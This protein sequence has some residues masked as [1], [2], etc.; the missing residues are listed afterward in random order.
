MQELYGRYNLVAFPCGNGGQ[1]MGL[2][3][4]KKATKMSDFKGMRVRTPGWFM[5]IMNYWAPRVT[6]LPGGEVY[7]ALRARRY[8]C[9]RIQL[10]G[11]QLSD[12]L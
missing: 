5:D 9:R 6:P 1:E 3:S 2:F 12:G 4:N 10:P 11:Y 8:R 7:L